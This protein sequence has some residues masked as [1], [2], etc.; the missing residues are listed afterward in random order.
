[1]AQWRGPFVAT[2]DTTGSRLAG[3]SGAE[4]LQCFT[5]AIKRGIE[6]KRFLVL[7]TSFGV[8]TFFLQNLSKTPVSG[9]ERWFAGLLFLELDVRMETGALDGAFCAETL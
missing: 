2:R 5:S 6:A 1:L 4:A 7:R 9:P 8:G 3:G